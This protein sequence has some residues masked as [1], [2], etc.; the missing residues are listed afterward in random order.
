MDQLLTKFG[1]KPLAPQPHQ[2][3]GDLIHDQL[4]SLGPRSSV[5]GSWGSV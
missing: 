4:I 1:H 2:Q 3:A 5:V